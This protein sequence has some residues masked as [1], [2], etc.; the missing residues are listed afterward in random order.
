VSENASATGE[1]PDASGHL[2]DDAIVIRGGLMKRDSLR[3]S[4]EAHEAENP[5]AYA[6]SFWSWPGLTAEEIARRVGPENLPH[7]MLR[8]YSAGQL[9][10]MAMSDGRPLELV[11]TDEDGHY[12]VILPP[13]PTDDDLDLFDHEFDPPEPNPARTEVPDA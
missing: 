3:I 11:P 4:A 12:D 1:L 2:P 7:K 9:R 8:K 6:L 10:N 13:P 5:G